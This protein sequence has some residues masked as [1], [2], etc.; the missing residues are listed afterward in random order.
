M[1]LIQSTTVTGTAT[2]SVV[3]SSIPQDGTHLFLNISAR[4]LL[5]SGGGNVT[6]V[7]LN[8]GRPNEISINGGTASVFPNIS[9]RG[10]GNPGIWTQINAT[11]PNY[12]KVGL[13]TVIYDGGSTTLTSG[14]N[15]VLAYTTTASGGTTSGTGAITQLT[16]SLVSGGTDQVI[17][18]NSRF[19]LY[20]LT[21][22]TGGA[23]FA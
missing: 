17:E 23:T 18:A 10:T 5:A 13:K 12:T 6:L 19:S 1:E 14:N 9:A 15:D 8:Q 4:T 7:P 11:I 20:K 2:T 3:F 21:A 16:V 22:G